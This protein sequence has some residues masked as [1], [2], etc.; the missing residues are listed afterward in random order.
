[1]YYTQ[2]LLCLLELIMILQ[3][4]IG[5]NDQSAFA[6]HIYSDGA[7]NTTNVATDA[8]FKSMLEYHLLRRD[9]VIES[10]TLEV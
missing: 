9:N 3:S 4:L 1:M 6:R 10:R 2:E 8:R 7:V 5:T